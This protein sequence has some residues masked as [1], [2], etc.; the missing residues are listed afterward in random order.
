M[1]AHFDEVMRLTS[2]IILIVSLFSY[3]LVILINIEIE[4]FW[5]PTLTS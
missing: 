1:W 5:M 4:A 3:L 2:R